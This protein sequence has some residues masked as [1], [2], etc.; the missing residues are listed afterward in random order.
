MAMHLIDRPAM[1]G[2]ALNA[3]HRG[4]GAITSMA[5][6]VAVLIAVAVAFRLGPQDELVQSAARLVPQHL[7]W[8]PHDAVGGGRDGGGDHST[9][10][11][12]RIEQVGR[13]AAS[14]PDVEARPSMDATAQ[15]PEDL[16]T[17]PARPMGDATQALAGTIDG[18]TAS[19]SAGPGSIGTGDAPSGDS[20]GGGT[21][22]GPGFGNGAVIGGPGVTM[23]VPIE[24]VKPQYTADAMR[25]HVQGAVWIECV[26]LPDGTVGD[27]RVMRSLDRHFG[28][29]EQAIAAAK[30]WRFRPGTLRGQAVPVIVTIELTFSLR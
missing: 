30:R 29:D 20:G 9:G 10:P 2:D 18:D 8:I 17:I 28:L 22:P 23:P 25:A 5:L 11:A 12:R 16:T 7:V 26:V 13:D 4:M 24:Q 19:R 1:A 15:P 6:H 3:P 21:Q 14:V 27:A